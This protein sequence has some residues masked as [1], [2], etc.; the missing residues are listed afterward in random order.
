MKKITLLTAIGLFS[1]LFAKAQTTLPLPAPETESISHNGSAAITK[2]SVLSLYPNPAVNIL[3]IET[4]HD[5]LNRLKVYDV[6]GNVLIN[7]NLNLEKRHEVD[8]TLFEKGVY[9]AEITT[10]NNT[11]SIR[12]FNKQ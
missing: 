4:G 8:V 9:F 10:E 11:S 6:L 1:I 5:R 12:K 2:Q 3:V 7:E